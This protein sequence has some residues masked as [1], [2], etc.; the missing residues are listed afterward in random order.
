MIFDVNAW[1]GVWP[2]RA[3]RDHT[4][5]ALVARLDRS[6]RQTHLARMIRQ[7]GRPQGQRQMP[8]VAP[9]IEQDQDGGSAGI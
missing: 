2:F 8:L 3:L 7:I 5:A 1:V 6:A 9:R 4:P